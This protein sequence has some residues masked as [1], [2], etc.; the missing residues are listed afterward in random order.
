MAVPLGR[1]ALLSPL[2]K[3]GMGV[4]WRGVE[5]QSGTPV[6]IKLIQADK[7]ADPEYI[8]S[9]RRETRAVARLDHPGIIQVHDFGVVDARAVEASGRR[10]TEGT[11]WLAMEYVS[12]TLRAQCRDLDWPR[13]QGIIEAL[14]DALAHAHARGVIHRD[15]KPQ[16]LLYATERDERP[17]LKL[18]DFGIAHAFGDQAG[19]RAGT[20]AYMAPEQIAGSWRDLGPWT[21]LY[22]VGC[23]VWKL[24][25]GRTPFTGLR[26]R[27]LFE[28]HLRKEPPEFV[29]R[30]ALPPDVEIWIRR[31][32][33]KRP[34]KRFARAHQAR[35]VLAL[36]AP[37]KP[38]GPPTTNTIIPPDEAAP[39]TDSSTVRAVSM[40]QRQKIPPD[41]RGDSDHEGATSRAGKAL[42][43]LGLFGLRVAPMVG[44][45]RPRDRI[46]LALHTSR[47]SRQLTVVGFT[48]ER[49]T[50]K[51]RLLDWTAERAHELGGFDTLRVRCR[52]EGDPLIAAFDE[53]LHL[54]GLDRAARA[55]RLKKLLQRVD[56]RARDGVLDVLSHIPVP[57]ESLATFQALAVEALAQEK[58]LIL[59]ID[60][61]EA[62]AELQGFLRFFIDRQSVRPSPVLAVLTGLPEIARAFEGGLDGTL[63]WAALGP[64]E[65]DARHEL[66][67]GVLG[68]A[69]SLA[70]HVAHQTDPQPGPLLQTVGQWVRRGKLT[71]GPDGYTMPVGADTG[72]ISIQAAW[73]D[74]MER[75]LQ[76]LPA[77]AVVLLELAAVLGMKVDA[78]RWKRA[79]AASEIPGVDAAVRAKLYARLLDDDLV[80]EVDGGW[81]FRHA[82]FRDAVMNRAKRQKRLPRHHRVCAS[83]LEQGFEDDHTGPEIGRH[84][85]GAGQAHEAIDRLLRSVEPTLRR[86]GPSNALG[87]VAK[88]EEA[89]AEAGLP[90]EDVRGLQIR[91]HRATLHQ[92]AG[93]LQAAAEVA[94]VARLDA[95]RHP[96][97]AA[98]C[99]LVLARCHLIQMQ[100]LLAETEA[101]DGLARLPSPP[102]PDLATALCGV[103][104][105]A[106]EQLPGRDA[107]APLLQARTLMRN[108]FTTTDT[109]LRVELDGRLALLEGDVQSAAKHAE[110]GLALARDSND[111]LAQQRALG[112]LGVARLRGG[113]FDGAES[114][115]KDALEIARLLGDASWPRSLARLLMGVYR[116]RGAGAASTLLR[117]ESRTLKRMS[118]GPLMVPLYLSIVAIAA[119]EADW[120][121]VEDLLEKLEG[122]GASLEA[123]ED[124]WV[125]LSDTGRRLMEAQ[126]PTASTAWRLAQN[127]AEFARHRSWLKE[128][129]EA[130]GQLVKRRR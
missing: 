40:G 59:A 44:R 16:N 124:N 111:L 82:G 86:N 12:S 112:L 57:E 31:L 80:R 128:A 104:S 18:S 34:E 88:C 113:D 52:E 72:A 130:L 89:V 35:E 66:L 114:A 46:W 97:L 69:D 2:A 125:A 118:D 53:L 115:F 76:G 58:R 102:P 13:L 7:A 108:R 28:A 63:D 70:Q 121:R 8:A 67:T 129:R 99:S 32:L 122:Y 77:G 107:V 38:V 94:R 74:R 109:R 17:G 36:M 78:D 6:A 73:K 123:S 79:I 64:L 120:A 25:T 30:M 119:W 105:E 65:D 62:S 126:R 37:P 98:R 5:T 101:T 95:G 29:P 68:L 41:W 81:A 14:L 87:L 1:F 90:P 26:G 24:A 100:W 11:P 91:V 15:L 22:A 10:L 71:A 96:A 19:E 4:V 42:P 43:G 23:V 103:L 117:R 45:Y 27:P 9:F 75:A 85:L 93:E 61:L 20:P 47:K 92:L 56:E 127:I 106:R 110:S 84:L 33:A 55:K 60:D 54:S 48:G 51:T 21:D 83:V 50:G 49:G 39:F 3:G 116:H